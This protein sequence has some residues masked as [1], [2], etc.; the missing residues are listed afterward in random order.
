[1]GQS[2][3]YYIYQVLRNHRISVA[4]PGET[5]SEALPVYF[6]SFHLWKCFKKVK[7]SWARLVGETTGICDALQTSSVGCL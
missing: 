7:T 5:K 1:M 4:H 3:A 2:Q 6:I